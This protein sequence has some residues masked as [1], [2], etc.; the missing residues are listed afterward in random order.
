[1]KTR[2]SGAVFLMATVLLAQNQNSGKSADQLRDLANQA[3]NSKDIQGEANYF[4]QAAALDEKKYE[5]KC[6]QAKE[7]LSKVL[8]QFQADFAMGSQKL[9]QKDYAGALQDLQEIRFGP[10]KAGAQELMQQA[11]I[12]INGGIPIDPASLA[13]FKT[14]RDAYLRGDFD[15]AETQLKTV[16]SQAL[17]SVV[18]QM[19]TNINVYR[20]TMKHADAMF[21]SGDL[22]GAEQK[23]Q[24]AATIHQNGPGSPLDRLRDVLAA[25]AR[26]EVATQEAADAHP[27]T[28]D[29]PMQ[30][31]KMTHA[32]KSRNTSD[33]AHRQEGMNKIKD[34]RQ[35]EADGGKEGATESLQEDPKEA[36]DSLNMGVADFYTSHFLQAEDAIGAYLQR[37]GKRYA[38]AAQFYLGASLSMQALL[39]AS[40]NQPQVDAFRKQAQDHFLLAKQLHY[41]PIESAVSPKVFAQWAQAGDQ[42]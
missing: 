10:N 1:M 40:Q 33:R 37:G 11:R 38:G 12:G 23:Y 27:A 18:N 35:T 36:T 39:A 22:K 24:F 41:K 32:A 21:Q 19:L 20:D 14:A 2:W 29:K 15:S 26:A 8:A 5:K 6:S 3:K 4:C 30:S 34:A 13:A 25:E 16:Q 42:Q 31:A 9:Q 17:H 7:E 28:P